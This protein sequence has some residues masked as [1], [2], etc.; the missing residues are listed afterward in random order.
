[1]IRVGLALG[2]SWLGGVNYYRNLLAAV[3]AL[4]DRQIE[5]VLL[6]GERADSGIL[7]G[8]PSLEV[9][10][11][12]WFDQPGPRWA[13]RKV[14][15]QA[16]ARDPFLD[17]FLRA[18]RIDVLSH[19]D[20]L[21]KR[22]H[23]PAICWITDFQHRE[24]PHYFSRFE[25]LYRDRDFKLQCR[26]AAR[27]VLSSY[28][29]QRA[30][31][32]FEPSAVGKSRVLQFVAQP[33]VG[34]GT[35]DLATL[36]ERYG[37]A[38]PYFH[39]PNQF[40]AHKNHKLIL[41]AM[42]VLRSQGQQVLV[43]STG[44]KEDYR[45]PHYFDRLM[46]HAEAAGVRD[47]FRVLGVIPYDDLVGLMLNSVA[48][49]NASRAEGWSTSVEEAK[50]LGKRIILS[51]L[52]VHREQAPLDGVYIDPDDAAGLARAM[53]DALKTF[54]PAVEAARSERAQRELPGRVQA[55]ARAYQE[56]VLEVTGG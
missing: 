19:S 35:A 34:A 11:S 53:G 49:V 44:A 6:I 46:A 51:D 54:D 43:I 16:F 5:P 3:A 31:S 22:A 28:D 1:M 10:R 33:R 24:L 56:I 25:R 42:A 13:V 4:P 55:F 36:Q 27:I 40:W 9:I 32:T 47:S 26:L 17:R 30:L 29:A 41:D 14:W 8:F 50:S 21:G 52:P 48:L 2:V 20:F 38:G 37:F 7:A 45:Q 12:R 15:Q 39:V 18:H 23:V